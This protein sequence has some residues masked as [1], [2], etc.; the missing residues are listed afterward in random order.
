MTTTVERPAA[1]APQAAPDEPA[2]PRSDTWRV[3][4]LAIL[5]ALIIGGV[6]MALADHDTRTAF[7]YFFQHPSDAPLDAWYTMRDAYKAL[8]EGAIYN[9][10]N[11]GG[12]DGVLGPIAGTI[13]TAAPLICAALGISLAFRAGLFNIGGQGQVIAGAMAA[14]Y[15][16]FAWHLPIVLHLVVAIVAGI[17]GGAFWGFIVGFLKARSGAHEVITTIML[18]YVALNGLAFLIQ[19][20]DI[21]NPTNPQTSKLILG[22]ARLPHLFGSGLQLDLGIVLA[23]AA[24]V[25]VWWLFTRSTLGFQL[26]SVGANPAAARGAGMSVPRITMTAMA[27]SGALTGLAGTLLALGGATSYAITPQIDNNVGFDAITVALLG[28]NSPKGVVGAGLLL[29]ALRAGAPTMQAQTGV[30]PDIVTVIQ[31]L[32]VI[33]VA[34]PRLTRAIFRLKG[35]GRSA[36]AGVTTNLVVTVSA[37]RAIRYPRHIV[38]GIS[39]AVL[40][41]LGLVVLGLGSR[42][43][44]QSIFHFSLPGDRFDLGS[45]SVEARPVVLVLCSLVIIAG[46]LR[47]VNLLAGKWAAAIAIFGLLASFMTWSIATDPSGLNLI[48]L[49]QGA[50][51]PSAIPL[52]LGSL[53]G[54]IGERSGVVNVALEGQLLLGAFAASFVGSLAH[55]AWVGIVAGALA[56]VLVAALLAVLAIR[57]LVDQVIAGVVLNLFV[58]GIT[59]FLFTEVVTQNPEKYNSSNAYLHIWKI[60]ILGD[61]PVLGPVFFDGTLFLYFAYFAVLAVSFGLFQTRWGLRLRAVGEHPRAADTVGIKVLRTRYQAMLIAGVIAGIGGAFLVVGEGQGG[62]FAEG[63]SS[64]KGYI[65]LAAVIFGRWTPRGAVLAALLFGFADQLQNLLGQ[66]SPPINPDLLGMAPYIATLFAVAGF[67]G[68]VRAPA[69]DGQPYTV[70]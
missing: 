65:A 37:A 67:V 4:A 64:G 15:V 30:P 25:G 29:G 27:L 39:Q 57:Y 45:W 17:A 60:P 32:I 51:F 18:N 66:A 50:L 68:R 58:L 9:P 40:G 12:V 48:S 22:S 28:R 8:F 31:A 21:Q 33:F 5:L 42:S 61:I 49:L 69:A 35:R 52:I 20:P 3:T 10:K 7:G 46:V 36:L 70:G 56:G 23:L 47:G 13:Y 24:A 54:V 19:T 53:A 26:R 34:A 11:T 6:L 2:A 1:P 41:A 59:N 55:N 14:G 62:T 43:R 63:M 38:T 16:G 44:H